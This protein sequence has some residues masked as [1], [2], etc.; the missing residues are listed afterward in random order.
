MYGFKIMISIFY[1][2]IYIMRYIYLYENILERVVKIKPKK[3][4]FLKIHGGEGGRE[5]SKLSFY[6]VSV[7]ESDKLI[8]Y[9]NAYQV[10]RSK[11][12][13]TF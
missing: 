13:I 6:G 1:P 11:I 12:F 7:I 8:R 3:P 4:C 9:Q 2:W 5:G 10:I